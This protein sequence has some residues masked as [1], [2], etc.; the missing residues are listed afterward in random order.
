M[1]KKMLLSM[2]RFVYRKGYWIFGRQSFK[3]LPVVRSLTHFVVSR[4][5]GRIAYVH[6]QK[7]HLDEQDSL[8]LS[9][10]GEFEPTETQLVR[11][12]I[13]PGYRVLDIGA[14]IGYYTLLFASLVGRDGGVIAFE[15]D[16]TNFRLLE[17]NV[18]ENGHTNV[19]LAQ[20]AIAEKSDRRLLY[21][22]SSNSGD[23]RLVPPPGEREV[24]EVE[25]A[26]L[27]EFLEGDSRR[28]DFIKMDIQGAEGWALQGMRNLIEENPSLKLLTEWSPSSLKLAG[29][30]P[31]KYLETLES[32]GF[33]LHLIGDNR[34]ELKPVRADQAD[35][36]G[37]LANLYCT[38]GDDA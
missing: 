16:P 3:R 34:F 25:C 4:F 17:K 37:E 29:Y 20:K 9:I 6:N 21:R 2:L 11:E 10:L 15:P 36:F 22:S 7:M 26:A 12:S 30:Q 1:W 28:I 19:T 33:H 18:A 8:R 31:T 14:H 38:K 13:K 24:V 23:H 5:K 32:M 35:E 27:D